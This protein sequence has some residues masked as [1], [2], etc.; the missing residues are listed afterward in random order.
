[1][2]G[3]RCH[4]ARVTI[5]EDEKPKVSFKQAGYSVGESDGTVTLDVS[6]DNAMGSDVVVHYRTPSDGR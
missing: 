4:S 5:L 3:Y 2:P 6:L 1:M